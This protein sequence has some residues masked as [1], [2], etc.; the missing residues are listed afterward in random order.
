MTV[1]WNKETFLVTLTLLA[2]LL[3]LFY[4]G[5]VYVVEPVQRDAEQIS[6]RYNEQQNLVNTYEPDQGLLNE[7]ETDYLSTETYLPIGDQANKVLVT[8]E[9][10]ANEE[11]VE[12]ISVSRL[13]D[14]QTVDTL[15]TSFVKNVYTA[16]VTGESP[17]NFRDLIDQLMSEE[18]VW[19]VTAFA[20][21]KTGENSYFGTF[22]FELYYYLETTE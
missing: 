12:L 9:E 16:D 2:V 19:N 22:T 15:P 14:R 8:L 13:S 4:Y 17:E 1:K 11:S 10:R 3:G 5:N 7:Y 18:R 21:E 20:Y 6:E